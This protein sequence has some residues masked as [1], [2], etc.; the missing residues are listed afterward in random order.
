MTPMPLT[1]VGL[2]HHQVAPDELAVLETV[3]G[4]LADRLL[5]SPVVCGV[6]VLATCNRFEV[7]LD[8]QAFHP[9]VELTSRTLTELLGAGSASIVDALQVHVGQGAVEHC[10]SVAAGLDSMVVGE[11][12]IAG[13][14]RAALAES[15]DRAGAALHR[16]FQ[17]ALATSKTVAS[18][19]SLGAA[20]RSVA[21]V[22]LGM[23]ESRYGPLS[24]RRVLLIGTG[25]YARVVSAELVRRGC[26]DVQVHSSTG[27]AA[28]F[29][30]SH[31]VRA[32]DPGALVDELARA[33]VVVTCS[34][35]N[36][37]VLTRDLV[38][39]ARYGALCALPIV[40]LALNGDV[41]PGVAELPGVDLIGLEAIGEHAPAEA[42]SAVLTAQ[43]I[44]A[45]AAETFA[46]LEGGRA[47]DP[48]VI[49]MRA[50][51][52]GIIECEQAL[53]ARKYPPEVA[54]AVARSLRR[55]SNSLMHTPS[56]R[57]QE[58]AR[59][60]ELDDYRRAMHTLFG[61]DV[62]VAP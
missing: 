29:A 49:A 54:Q 58:L 52:M 1:V 39:Q 34:G 7:Y 25:A 38:A 8:A 51:I 48:A 23:V 62:P 15:G 60:G 28:A 10:L 41:D 45:R 37:V 43:D 42:A 47:A 26:T 44:V 32:I 14:V 30:A 5:A 22:G 11:A 50:H 17:H 24:Q 9:A 20:G 13:Q 21:S 46:H 27:R 59:T 35:S 18:R 33:E 61:I 19:T 3:A 36:R 31:P 55:V 12:E 56:V 16:L 4:A 40:D 53:V 57:A 2:S 6:I